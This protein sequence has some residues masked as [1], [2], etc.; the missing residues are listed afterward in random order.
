MFPSL[1]CL[2]KNSASG[3]WLHSKGFIVKLSTAEMIAS[4]KWICGFLSSDAGSTG[5]DDS[6]IQCNIAT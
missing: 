2:V 3:A 6:T 4:Q 5:I 1:G